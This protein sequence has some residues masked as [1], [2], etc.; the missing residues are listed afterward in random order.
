MRVPILIILVV[1]LSISCTKINDANSSK[2]LIKQLEF[3]YP[4]LT[5]NYQNEKSIFKLSR[6]IIDNEWQFE[7]E[8]YDNP[9]NNTGIL[10]VRKD[11]QSY[12]IPLFASDQSYY[13][14]MQFKGSASIPKQNINT[15]FE[16]ELKASNKKL[17]ISRINFLYF[18]YI[19]IHVLQLTEDPGDDT[20]NR[21]MRFPMKISYSGRYNIVETIHSRDSLSLISEPVYSCVYYDVNR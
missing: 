19:F 15:T 20:G 6:K 5:K 10:I 7:M 16:R 11:F 3:K 8:L 2:N 9:T 17:N 21:K 18:R 14:Q 1:A 12:A 13:W 4:E